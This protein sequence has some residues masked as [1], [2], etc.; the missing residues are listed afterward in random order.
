[1]EALIAE[2]EVA[3][4]HTFLD[5]F[6]HYVPRRVT[7]VIDV[8]C[9]RGIVGAVVRIYRDPALLIGVDVFEPYIRFCEKLGVYNTLQRQDLRNLPLP[10]EDKSFDLAV[11]LEVL[12][13]LTK[14][15]GQRL[16]DELNR[17]STMV[18]VST[19]NVF[20]AQPHFDRNPFQEH[21][22][23]WSSR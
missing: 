9:G 7:K 3:W 16:L 1:M 4:T 22:S 18:I 17:I 6:L 15:E 8:G 13:H 11:S 21:L 20:F 23:R 19:P 12:E 14:V 5:I 2:P 10:Y